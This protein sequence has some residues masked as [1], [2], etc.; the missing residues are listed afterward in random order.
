MG[1]RLHV[2]GVDADP[3]LLH[4]ARARLEQ[5]ERRW[6]RFAPDSDISRLNQR[7]PG[8]AVTVMVEADTITLLQRMI[9]GWRATDGR[10]NP[11]VLCRLVASGYVASRTDST[12]VTVLPPWAGPEMALDGI[13][14]DVVRRLVTLPPG[15][16]LDAGGIG[17]GLAADLTVSW[18]LGAGAGG[19]LVSIGGDLAMGGTPPTADGWIIEVEHA[20]RSDGV[21]CSLAV[22]GGGVATSSIVSRTWTTAGSTHH[23]VIDPVSGGESTTDLAA[24]TVLA[25]SAWQAEVFATSALLVGTRGAVDELERHGLDGMAIDRCGNVLCTYDLREL[26]RVM[27]AGVR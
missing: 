7:A 17:K 9:E 4:A 24:V 18:L 1:C 5:L 12:R 19:A 2:I 22:A 25:P 26:D 6:T 15:M 20:D 23:H 16:V 14:I 13:E 10:Y 21:L 11:T 27:E 3:T 8:P